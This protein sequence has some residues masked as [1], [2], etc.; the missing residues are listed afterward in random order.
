MQLL[1][2]VFFV[3]SMTE[4]QLREKYYRATTSQLS[5]RVKILIVPGHDRDASGTE[6]KNV[7]ESDVNIELA[8]YL[9]NFLKEDMSFDVML[10]RDRNGYHPSL[11]VYFKQAREDIKNFRKK[12]KDIMDEMVSKG[13]IDVRRKVEH[14][15]APS[16]TVIKL[17]G[18][19]KWSNENDIDIVIH[20]HFNDYPDRWRG[21]AGKYS[22]HS[23]YVP[24]R[25]FSNAKVSMALAKPIFD[26][27]LTRSAQSN[28]PVE[29]DGIIEDQELIAVGSYNSLDAA[30]LLI[31]YGYIYESQFFKESVSPLSLKEMAF[32]THRGIQNFFGNGVSKED[33]LAVLFPHIWETNLGKGNTNNK[34]T[35]L[36]QMALLN[37]NVYPPKGFTK[38]NCPLSGSYF[39]CTK[40]AVLAFQKKYGIEQT[41][42]VG[43]LTRK[44]LNILYGQ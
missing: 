38:N 5:E 19:N 11:A 9:A 25:Q 4:M 20:I 1:A 10:A 31:E 23:I 7:K 30:A 16:E 17:Y 34:D 13:L 39:S 6:F 33:A 44:Q 8:E 21:S 41:G 3:D 29:S 14:N 40:R 2:G 36:L 42:F 15:F 43:P 35:F 12:H 32:Q 37:E 26:A 27:L 28:I 22:G 24:E 18:I